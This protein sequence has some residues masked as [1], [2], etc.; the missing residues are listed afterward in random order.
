MAGE[1]NALTEDI[2]AEIFI[3]IINTITF[4]IDLMAARPRLYI[5]CR[6]VTFLI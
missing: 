6:S 4:Q 2:R 1:V 3:M 5:G